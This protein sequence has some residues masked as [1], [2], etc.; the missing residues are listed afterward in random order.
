MKIRQTAAHVC[1]WQFSIEPEA[2]NGALLGADL[3][4]AIGA[5]DR[6]MAALTA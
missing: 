3:S 5:F 4:F 1:I 2:S 6:C